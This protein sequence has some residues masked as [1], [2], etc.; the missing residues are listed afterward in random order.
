MKTT[1]FLVITLK[2]L[3]TG[4]KSVISTVVVVVGFSIAGLL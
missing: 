4:L 1:L 3:V 2:A